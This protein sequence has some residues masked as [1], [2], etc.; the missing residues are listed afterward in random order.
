MHHNYNQSAYPFS[1]TQQM[2][3]QHSLKS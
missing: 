2:W 3:Q 1:S